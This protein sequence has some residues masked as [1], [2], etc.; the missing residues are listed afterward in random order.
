MSNSYMN[1][2]LHAKSYK[3]SRKGNWKFEFPIKD[4]N[5]FFVKIKWNV[6]EHFPTWNPKIL[7]SLSGSLSITFMALKQNKESFR[8]NMLVILVQCDIFLAYNS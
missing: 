5:N 8:P 3:N 6:N 2:L 1:L 7:G 4:L